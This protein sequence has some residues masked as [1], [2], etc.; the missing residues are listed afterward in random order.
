LTL[1]LLAYLSLKEAP[2][3][4]TVRLI[5][6]S[7]AS[8]AGINI[9][10]SLLFDGLLR[11]L[12][13]DTPRI[14]ADFLAGIS[15]VVAA[16]ILLSR[17]GVNLS[18]I[19]ATSAVFTA[20]I[21]FS[22]QDTLGNLMGGLALQLEKSLRPGD[23]VEIDGEVGRVLEVRWRQTSIETRDW[24][25]IVIPNSQLSKNRF[26]IL[27]RRAGKPRQL[28]QH[29]FFNVDYRF[30]PTD[31]IGAL[32]ADIARAPIDGVSF[33]P[34]PR[35]LLMDMQES[36]NH[37]ALRY[38][39]SNLEDDEIVDSVV[40]TRIFFAL[41][42]AGIPLTLPAQA[43]FL[44]HETEE[45]KKRKR[46]SRLADRSAALRSVDLFESLSDEELADL[47]SALRFSPY[48]KGEVLTRQGHEGTDLFLILGGEVDV[49]VTIDGAIHTVAQLGAGSFF[50]ERSLLTG[51]PRSATTV[52]ASDVVCY[53]LP[54]SAMQAL[55]E[56]RP[57]LAEG[58]AEVLARRQ[59][60]LDELR[61]ETDDPSSSERFSQSRRQF[62]GKIRSFFGLRRGVS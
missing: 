28:R 18:G 29:L 30:N 38:F 11:K 40:H 55:L 13:V 17:W 20:V 4:R 15:Y 10:V 45:R 59:S 47:A 49:R 51:E 56:K 58:I 54:K 19:I 22:M 57:E 14:L 9:A 34:A 52:A 24:E 48:S 53:E 50:G 6:L 39:L 37:Y 23:W 62:L 42:R 31:V 61:K 12:N 25:T 41:K 3:Y 21:G 60:E 26:K 36:Y 46:H 7:L 8:L 2:S 44:T 32:E 5:S 35:C 27:G 43:V 16:L 1:P 33:E